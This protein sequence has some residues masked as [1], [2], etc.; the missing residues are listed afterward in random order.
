MLVMPASTYFILYIDYKPTVEVMG[1]T[2][3]RVPTIE[4]MEQTTFT[5]Q[6]LKSWRKQVQAKIEPLILSI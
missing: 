1:A 3:R 2:C 6:Q 5:S 4:V